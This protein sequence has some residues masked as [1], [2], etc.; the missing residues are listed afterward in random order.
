MPVCKP[1]YRCV[2]FTDISSQWRHLYP[3]IRCNGVC[4]SFVDRLRATG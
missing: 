2:G 3:C 4:E 1:L